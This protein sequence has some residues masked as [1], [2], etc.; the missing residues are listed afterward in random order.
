MAS[1]GNVQSGA[2]DPNAPAQLGL[3]CQMRPA[4]SYQPPP[5]PTKQSRYAFNKC[6][7]QNGGAYSGYLLPEGFQGVGGTDGVYYNQQANP[8][9]TQ[10]RPYM[11]GS[12]CC[13]VHCCH[14]LQRHC[15]GN[16]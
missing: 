6:S 16:V 4:D 12:R 11:V 14:R 8:I 7:P 3:A 5:N 10:P 9:D 1:L 15:H 13:C 2:D